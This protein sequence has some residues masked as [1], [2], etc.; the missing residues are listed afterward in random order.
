MT[1]KSQRY[2]LELMNENVSE[3]NKMYGR[4]RTEK[5]L[6]VLQFSYKKDDSIRRLDLFAIF[7]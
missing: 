4:K 3:K 5:K 7:I 6:H 2:L 1:K